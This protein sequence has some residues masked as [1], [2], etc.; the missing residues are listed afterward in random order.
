[1]AKTKYTPPVTSPSAARR[2]VL[3]GALMALAAP[4]AA[5]AEPNALQRIASAANA[6]TDALGRMDGRDWSATVD[7]ENGFVLML[8]GDAK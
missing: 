5:T 6:L 3:L 8:R 2:G 1:M 4:K 7:P